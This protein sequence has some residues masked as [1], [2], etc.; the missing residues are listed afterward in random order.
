MRTPP[1]NT[2]DRLRAVAIQSTE[3]FKCDNYS[4]SDIKESIQKHL[5]QFC[6]NHQVLARYFPLTW[7]SEIGTFTLYTDGRCL[8]H[9]ITPV[10]QIDITL[11]ISQN[12]FQIS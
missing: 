5:G 10:T 7:N 2:K 1:T 4:L 12:E 3:K 6:N 8:F 11:K 9:P